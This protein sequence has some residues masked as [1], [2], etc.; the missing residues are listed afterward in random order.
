MKIIASKAFAALILCL[1]SNV[2]LADEG[3][4]QA[5]VFANMYSKI[6]LK[7][8]SDLEALREKLKSA[9]KLPPEKA[10]GFL[11]GHPG[12]AWPMPDKHG[13][14]VLT[15]L[16]GKNFCAI[17]VRRAN[18]EVAKKL[19]I[20]IVA[21][22]P[23]PLVAKQ[24]LN[25]QMHTSA[26]GQIHTIAYEWSVPNAPRKMLFTLTTA[27]SSNAQLQVLGSAAIIR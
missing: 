5:N 20:N 18:T 8:L 26:N 23:S 6:C 19:F 22:A 21:T 9:P 12:D 11:A 2:S 1:T 13:L 16:S 3:E 14:F 10:T 17:H 4:N 7:N 24:V 25:E 15:L 27:P